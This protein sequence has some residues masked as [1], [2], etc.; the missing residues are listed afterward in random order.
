M[1][2][3]NESSTVEWHSAHWMPTE[4]EAFARSKKPVTPTTALQLQQRE[5][6]RRIVEIDRPRRSCL[7]EPAGS[8]STSTLSPSSSALFGL[9]PGPTPPIASP[10]I[11]SCSRS[12]SPQNSSSPNV[13]KRN[14]CRPSSIIRFACSTMASSWTDRFREAADAKPATRAT[15]RI[16]NVEM[17]RA[18][19]DEPSGDLRATNGVDPARSTRI[20]ASRARLS[21]GSRISA[22]GS[23]RDPRPETGFDRRIVDP[24]P[25]PRG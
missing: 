16:T 1:P 15:D 24:R 5:R 20:L 14:V 12:S 2:G 11:A 9:T 6:G 7:H 22:E 23:V 10:W 19:M 18:R 17:H 8:A 3:A 21:P 4:R 13:S 25:E